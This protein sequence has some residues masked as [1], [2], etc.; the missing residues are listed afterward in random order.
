MACKRTAWSCPL[1]GGGEAA[2][3]KTKKERVG[4]ASHIAMAGVR[5][6]RAATIFGAIHTRSTHLI[7]GDHLVRNIILFLRHLV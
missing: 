1:R 4:P 2:I 7:I 3:T 5:A 6:K